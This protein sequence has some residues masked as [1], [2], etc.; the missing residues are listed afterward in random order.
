MAASGM[1]LL[2]IYI[3]AQAFPMVPHQAFP[4]FTW[5]LTLYHDMRLPL[6]LSSHKPVGMRPCVGNQ[7]LPFSYFLS[8]AQIYLLPDIIALSIFPDNVGFTLWFNG[9]VVKFPLFDTLVRQWTKTIIL[10][11]YFSREEVLE[12]SKVVELGRS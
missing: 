4:Q 12:D 5:Y 1:L 6:L 8:H 9:G 11:S 10:G 3:S 7:I 2:F